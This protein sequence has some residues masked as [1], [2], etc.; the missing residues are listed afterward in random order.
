MANEILV[1]GGGIGGMA[2]ALALAR[3]GR[4]VRVLEKA[5]EFGEI[6][7]GIQVGPNAYRM[8]QHLDVWKRMEHT[9]F[10]PDALI[11]MD[12][13]DGKEVGRVDLGEDY[14][15]RYGAPYFVIHRRDIHG[16]L[17]DACKEHENITLMTSKG[18][19]SFE[20]RG[21]G[22][23]VTCEDGST[24]EGAAVVAAD[25]LRS[26]ARQTIVGDG[27]PRPAGHVAYRGVVPIDEIVNKDHQNAMVIWV[28]HNMHLVQYRLRGG[29]VMNN[30]AVVCS[31]RFKR[32][33]AVWGDW[34]ELEETFSQAIPVVRDM[35]HRYIGRDRNWVLHDR[36]PVTN[37]TKG[38]VTLLGDAA[39]PTLQYLAQGACMA[40]EDACVLA[41]RV[42]SGAVDFNAAFLQYQKE[43]YLRCAR[44]VLSARFF[45]EVCHAGK[46]ARDLRN[47]YCASRPANS[48]H[49]FD[50]LY[51]GIQL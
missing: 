33:E 30:V 48:Y 42:G 25:G 19:A 1:I 34:N 41:E 6:G 23:V 22:V 29:T 18:L 3:K 46:A 47:A 8:L 26:V 38:K 32:G 24:F 13:V 2:A 40:I 44:I 39:H 17:W 15:R 21:S 7:Y 12:A 20:E 37:W 9:A 28:G 31:E 10:F 43:R 51:R 50:W 36:D 4:K 16:G 45:G 49:E 11:M 14:K 5:P 27:G 35:L